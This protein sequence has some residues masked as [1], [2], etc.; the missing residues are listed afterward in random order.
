MSA[1]AV[2]EEPV[3]MSC[4]HEFCRGCWEGFLNLKIQEG[5]AHNICCP[6]VG[7]SQ[8]VPVDVIESVVSREM[9]RR[10]LQ[11]DIKAFVENN[12]AIR[13]CP[14]A[15][16]ERAVRLSGPGTADPLGFPRLRAPAVDCGRG[17]LFCWE[18]RGEAHEPCDCPTWRAWLQKVSEMRP[19]E[20]EY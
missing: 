8:L 12:P 18:C 10:Y 6:A 5:E 16:C 1:I 17:H 4:G 14:E 3:Y 15:G 20:R 2:F 9:D 7:C 19:D 11:F 13:W